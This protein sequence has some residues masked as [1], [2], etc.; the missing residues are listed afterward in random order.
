MKHGIRLC[1]FGNDGTQVFCVC[2]F[3]P[4][5]QRPRKGQEPLSE[6]NNED[7]L[8][9]LL[10]AFNEHIGTINRPIPY[11]HRGDVGR[12]SLRLPSNT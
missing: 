9:P 2:Q 11:E 6:V 10:D 12:G 1:R 4:K 5:G 7:G 3:G 8:G